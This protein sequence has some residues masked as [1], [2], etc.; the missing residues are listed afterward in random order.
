[1]G[2][3][4]A[5]VIPLMNVDLTYLY[6]QIAFK[7]DPRRE[8][9]PGFGGGRGNHYGRHDDRHDE[10]HND[11]YD[12]RRRPRGDRDRHPEDGRR[13]RLDRG[14]D[15]PPRRPRDHPDE[16]QFG[17]RPRS[18][19]RGYDDRYGDR[20][21]DRYDDRFD[22]QYDESHDYRH[23]DRLDDRHDNRRHRSRSRRGRS[24]D[25][26]RDRRLPSPEEDPEWPPCFAKDGSSFVFDNRSGMFY[27]GLSDFF[28]DPKNKL[29]YSN[30]KGSY[31]RYDEKEDPPFVKV[32]KEGGGP[33]EASEV[34]VEPIVSTVAK[35]KPM[36]AINLKTIKKIKGNKSSSGQLKQQT[37]LVSKEQKLRIANI[38]KWSE[39]QAE[40]KAETR[41]GD[42]STQK[43]QW[44]KKGKPICQLCQRKFQSVEKLRLHERE[45]EMH[46]QNLVKL[47]KARQANLKRKESPAG[48]YTDRAQRRRDLHD[49]EAPLNA[50]NRM[51]E[52]TEPMESAAGPND[53]LGSDNIGNQLLRKMGWKE[54]DKSEADPQD[55]LRKDWDR[56]ENLA[57]SG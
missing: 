3:L 28:Y 14:Y 19:S 34:T 45:S 21:D 26:L 55:G 15:G 11:R 48:T 1:M 33:L 39:K 5:E 7:D 13:G 57:K 49:I 9:D 47:E 32:E 44:T 6:L 41:L 24:P 30:T 16:D 53:T 38:E 10:R 52:P 29:Y 56:I 54:G 18:D 46:M 43:I 36:I 17:R 37:P 2:H 35:A 22:D 25:R 20:Y 42:E 27:E 40:L 31:F 12:D 4:S 51:D 50:P 8:E 23:Y